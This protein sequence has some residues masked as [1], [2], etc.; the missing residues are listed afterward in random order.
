MPRHDPLTKVQRSERMSRIRSRDTHPELKVRQ[1]LF[2]RGYRY[3]LHT[4]G[5]PGRPD[6]VFAS[7]K[8]IILVHGCFWHLH[9]P[10]NH[11]RFPRTRVKFW[12]EKLSKN[13]L[14]DVE[15]VKALKKAGWKI[16]TVWECELKKFDALLKRIERFLE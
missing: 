14:R 11:Y 1:A 3:R 15:V 13:R 7:R 8:K 2:A 4:K 12:T 10:C 6:I 9:Q 5:L 16:F